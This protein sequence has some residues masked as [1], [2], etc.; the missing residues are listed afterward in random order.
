[1]RS[2]NAVQHQLH[3]MYTSLTYQNNRRHLHH[4]HHHHHHHWSLSVVSTWS[5]WAGP[6]GGVSDWVLVWVIWV[7]RWLE[8]VTWVDRWLVWVTWVDRWPGGRWRTMGT[9]CRLRGG[10]SRGSGCSRSAPSRRRPSPSWCSS[11]PWSTCKSQ[12]TKAT[13]G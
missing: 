1:M 6:G 12:P 5:G 8:W 3:S 7:D 10:W 13:M 9:A 4:H 11:I 2:S